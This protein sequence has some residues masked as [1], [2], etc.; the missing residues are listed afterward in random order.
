MDLGAVLAID[1]VAGLYRLTAEF[2]AAQPLAVRI[3]TV[4][5]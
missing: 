3:A 1:D 4:S 2:L 5:G